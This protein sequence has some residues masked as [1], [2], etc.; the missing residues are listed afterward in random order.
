MFATLTLACPSLSQP[1]VHTSHDDMIAAPKVEQWEDNTL[2]FSTFNHTLPSSMF[3]AIA[4]PSARF[5]TD[6]LSKLHRF[7]LSFS[8][9]YKRM[10]KSCF[11]PQQ[12]LASLA[13][14]EDDVWKSWHLLLLLGKGFSTHQPCQ[15][16]HQPADS[17]GAAEGQAARLAS[18]ASSRRE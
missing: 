16:T 11:L 17:P 3:Q 2:R 4:H 13:G 18:A 9:K 8:P 5:A 14:G 15:P 10:S 1:A 12:Y 6:L 7:W